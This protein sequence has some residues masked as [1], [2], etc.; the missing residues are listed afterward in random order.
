MVLLS[1]W[2]VLGHEPFWGL[3]GRVAGKG[4][5]KKQGKRKGESGGVGQDQQLN[6]NQG[7]YFHGSGGLCGPGTALRVPGLWQKEAPDSGY[8]ASFRES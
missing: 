8:P 2:W 1:Y 7:S 3:S 4:K 5:A 6:H